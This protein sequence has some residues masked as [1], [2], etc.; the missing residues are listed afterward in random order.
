[1]TAR[2]V[3]LGPQESNEGPVSN[4]PC[5]CTVVRARLGSHLLLMS[6]ETD[7]CMG[8]SISLHLDHSPGS[9]TAADVSTPLHVLF[10]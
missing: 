2:V 10:A 4:I 8:T 1:M 5:Y 9:I 7:C 3:L 6:G